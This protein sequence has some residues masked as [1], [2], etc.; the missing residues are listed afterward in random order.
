MAVAKEEKLEAQGVAK[1]HG[2]RCRNAG[3]LVGDLQSLSGILRADLLFL[4]MR[5][6]KAIRVKCCIEVT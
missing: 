5:L 6:L 3:Q 2:P 4:S 1:V